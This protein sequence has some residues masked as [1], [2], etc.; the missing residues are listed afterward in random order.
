V[1]ATTDCTAIFKFDFKVCDLR[2]TS[3]VRARLNQTSARRF[4]REILIVHCR[5]SFAEQVDMSKNAVARNST[6][7]VRMLNQRGVETFTVSQSQIDRF[8]KCLVKAIVTG[9]LPFSWVENPHLN[10][11]MRAIGIPGMTR[12]CAQA[13]GQQ[14]CALLR[15]P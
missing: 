13:A 12:N 6:R 2:A 5:N 11:G 1:C 14:A 3:T 15:T 7:T 4:W 9:N 10:E 8:H